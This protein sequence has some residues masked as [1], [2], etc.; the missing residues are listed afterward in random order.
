MLSKD[1]GQA[2][3][4]IADYLSHRDYQTGQT[5]YDFCKKRGFTMSEMLSGMEWQDYI[6][7]R[8]RVIENELPSDTIFVPRRLF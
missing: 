8:G 3:E 2:Q 7:Q 6:D 5:W 1:F 4:D